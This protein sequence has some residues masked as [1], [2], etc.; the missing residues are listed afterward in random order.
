MLD[1]FKGL[2]KPLNKWG[3]KHP[4]LRQ[5]GFSGTVRQNEVRDTPAR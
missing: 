4:T 5:L 1:K 3:P 2:P